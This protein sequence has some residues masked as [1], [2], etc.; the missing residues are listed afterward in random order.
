MQPSVLLRSIRPGV[1]ALSAALVFAVS[2]RSQSVPNNANTP[3]PAAAAAQA[4]PPAPKPAPAA[5]AASA[6]ATNTSG[7]NVVELNPFEVQAASDNSYGALESNSLTNF[8][9]DLSKLP[10]TADV[11]T[12]SFM[13]DVSATSVED[14]IAEYAGGGVSSSNP[15]AAAING[16]PGDRAGSSLSIRGL[17]VGGAHRDG[18]ISMSINNK[19]PVGSTD[20]FSTERVELIEGPQALLYGSGGLG[21]V[22]NIVSKQA[23]F[24]TNFGSFSYRLDQYGSKR[25]VLDYGYG[26]NNVAVRVALLD[27]D[28][29][30]RRVLLGG[31][32]SGGY[33]QL[34]FRLPHRTT[35]R[36]WGQSVDADTDHGNRPGNLNSFLTLGK[37]DP[38]YNADPR[39]LMATNQLGDLDI[40]NGGLNWNNID[41][42]H[43][44][45][46]SERVNDK[47]A[48]LSLDTVW[49]RW[50]SSQLAVIYDDTYDDRVDSGLT[51]QPAGTG[52]NP[53]AN[54]TAIAVTPADTEEPQREKAVRFSLLA[55]NDFFHGHAHSQ[56][57]A[58]IEG[59]K[60]TGGSLDYRYYQADANGNIL[61]NGPTSADYFGRTP[62]GAQWYSIQNG[63]PKYPVFQ[64]GTAMVNIGGVNY[65]RQ[66]KMFRDPTQATP[67][68][69]Q[70]IIGIP[71]GGHYDHS[72][73]HVHAYYLANLT[74]W[75]NDRIETVVG[76]RHDQERSVNMGPTKTTRNQNAKTDYTAGV[77]VRALSWLRPFADISTGFSG[78]ASTTDPYGVP[79]L[80]PTAGTP[81]PD[82]GVKFF[83]PSHSFAGSFTYYAKNTM[84]NDAVTIDTSIYNAINPDTNINSGR[85]GAVTA[86]DRWVNFD[87]TSKGMELTLTANPTRNW[88]AVFRATDTDGLVSS[89][90]SFKQLY[91]DQFN[92]NK[93]GQVTYTDGTPVMVPNLNSKKKPTGGSSILTMA[94]LNDP[95]NVYYA[96]PDPDSGAIT[97]SLLVGAAGAMVLSTSH[98]TVGTGNIGLPISDIQVDWGDPNGHHGVITPF[99]A[100]QDTT[101]YSQY[102]LS[103][104]NYYT[105]DHGPLNGLG[106]GFGVNGAYKDRSYYY[107]PSTG[108]ALLYSKPSITVCELVVSYQRKL[109]GKYV[110]KTQ[111]NIK[112]LFNHYDVLVL[113]TAI[114]GVFNQATLSTEPRMFIWTNSIAF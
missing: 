98:G 42:F 17:S 83:T 16:A 3:A 31:K 108:P 110:W 1:F 4:A 9:A 96:A 53:F 95:N 2:A 30:Y 20:S 12:K 82:F 84:K 5:P 81:T 60:N 8:R 99:T 45:W 76:L 66:S 78:G 64:P 59:G 97:N 106:L 79:L 33:A 65:V 80:T 39:Y 63:P 101:G 102:S 57:I 68:N 10:I 55:T 32:S 24:N 92:V 41:S 14:M 21:G 93:A 69:P 19:G 13:D 18:F 15:S 109:W 58:G 77:S 54:D 62:L 50:L 43:S 44:Q 49:N 71:N 113:P 22:V 23:R 46:A 103:L 86:P 56:T 111:L 90:S 73:T 72:V 47:F 89:G 36:I 29:A 88:R 28:Q 87:R 34:A 85:Y 100:G 40:V 104:F 37:K 11:F 48:G 70:G 38:R 25:S 91:N 67:D 7:Q 6:S 94:M 114:N 112:N 52:T 61:T 74:D 27:Q 107:T 35:L 26:D 51:F 75:F 105:V